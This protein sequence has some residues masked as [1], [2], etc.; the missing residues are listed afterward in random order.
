MTTS[1][2][3]APSSTLAAILLAAAA[4]CATDPA[5]DLDG[6]LDV[7]EVSAAATNDLVLQAESAA[8]TSPMHKATDD[9]TY[10][11]T[12][13]TDYAGTTAGTAVL[14]FTAP[15]TADYEVFVTGKASGALNNSIFLQVDS[16]ASQ[17]LQLGEEYAPEFP[18]NQYREYSVTTVHLTAGVH[19]ITIRGREKLARIDQLRLRYTPPAKPKLG[20]FEYTWDHSANQAAL[21]ARYGLLMI[22]KRSSDLAAT[23]AF[24]S[25]VKALNPNIRI[26][27]YTMFYELPCSIDVVPTSQRARYQPWLTMADQAGFWL[28]TAA[29]AKTS[30]T[31]EYNA[32]DMNLTP[33]GARNASNQT[34]AEYMWGQYRNQYYGATPALDYV[35]IDNVFATAR[36][37]TRADYKRQ[38][39]DLDGKSAEISTALRQGYRALFDLI[40]RTNPTLKVFANTDNDLSSP[41]Y[42][43]QAEGAL[44]EN[45]I[46]ESGSQ[47][48][49]WSTERLAGWR[50]AFDHYRAVMA[51]TRAPHDVMFNVYAQHT[52][53]YGVMRYG[54]ATS[55]LD[56]GF[57]TFKIEGTDAQPWF[58]EYDAPIGTPTDGATE[59]A[60]HAWIRH[61]SNGLVLV[62]P[63]SAPLQVNV[64][65]GYKRLSGTQDPAVN[66]GRVESTVTLP[67]RAGLLM[68]K[69]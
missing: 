54:L 61:Y 8:L 3:F 46:A 22:D 14:S 15:V 5:D 50:G 40:R 68:L 35:M 29:G 55:M 21:D 41:E 9:R 66:N 16:G 13:V 2:S 28:R 65:A 48:D 27:A 38:G 12:T 11:E 25:A 56:N 57:Y 51:H 47:H 32:C 24:A 19:K 44:I 17:V 23:N 49:S 7:S 33:W 37:R 67:A 69:A 43:N 20:M 18:W 45:L 6:D 53:A 63:T 30:W 39:V 42:N 60:N 1:R 34:W 31:G 10:I 4:G 36:E 59:L 52:N 64:G 26:G 58:D 62:N